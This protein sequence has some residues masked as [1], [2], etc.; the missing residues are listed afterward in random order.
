MNFLITVEDSKAPFFLEL[1]KNLRSVKVEP[2]SAEKKK[3][4]KEI[5]QSVEEVKAAERGEIKLRPAR[6][7]LR[8]L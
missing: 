3:L 1:F 5:R 7:L 6:E 4:I 8:E 2:L